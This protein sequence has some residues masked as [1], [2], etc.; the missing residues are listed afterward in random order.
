MLYLGCWQSTVRGRWTPVQ[1]SITTPG[2][3]HTD[4]QWAS[5]FIDRRKMLQAETAWLTL[6]VILKLAVNGLT[7]VILTVLSTV[8]LQFQGWF[9]LISLRPVLKSVAPLATCLGYKLVI[10]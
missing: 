5:T 8:N 4:N 9:V 7:S 2:P 1:R 10:M 6:T 3:L